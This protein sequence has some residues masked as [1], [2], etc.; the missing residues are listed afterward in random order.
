MPANKNKAIKYLEENNDI[1][2]IDYQDYKKQNNEFF[3]YFK[4]FNHKNLIKIYPDKV[5]CNNEIKGKCLSNS[6]NEAYFVDDTH[7]S[8]SGG[9]L[10]GKKILEKLK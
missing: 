2:S 6:K 1:L 3:L 10:I 8:K 7:L 5:F 4:N 9:R